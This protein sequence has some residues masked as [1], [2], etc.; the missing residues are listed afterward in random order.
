M[1]KGKWAI[2]H[3]HSGKS[4]TFDTREQAADYARGHLRNGAYDLEVT[5]PDGRRGFLGHPNEDGTTVSGG[6]WHG[7]VYGQ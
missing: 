6:G 3:D 7:D 5:T 1:A 4:E 2:H